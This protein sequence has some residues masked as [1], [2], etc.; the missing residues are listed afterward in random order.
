MKTRVTPTSH[1]L[2]T[3]RPVM[4]ELKRK[5]TDKTRNTYA[6][7]GIRTPMF[8]VSI[9]DLKTIA[10][11]I[12]GNQALALELYDSGNYDA[13]YL[14]GMVADGSHMSKKQLQHWVKTATC[15]TLSAYTVPWVTAESPFAHELAMKWIASNKESIV[16][17]GWGTYA[18]IVATT[19]D[20]DLNL[21][22]IKELLDR[23]VN[24]IDKAPNKVRYMMN[25]FV[26]AVGGYVK[27][28]LQHAKK[29]A[30]TIGAVSVDMG[31]TACKVPRTLE[32]IEKIERLGRVGKKRKT[33]KC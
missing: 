11:R 19:R 18:G 9:A 32:Y 33:M 13:M 21:E 25:Q 28:L 17:S 22:E 24:E 16:A 31:D 1:G 7:H 6:R 14:A 29:A 10:K 5:G 23:V 3:I 20:E 27:P 26:I 4:A 2:T 12:R 15:E 8:G 30:Q